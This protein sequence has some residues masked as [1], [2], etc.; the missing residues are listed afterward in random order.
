VFVYQNN[1]REKL[2]SASV[3]PVAL[4]ILSPISVSTSSKWPSVKLAA[5]FDE[6]VFLRFYSGQ[7]E[8]RIELMWAEGPNYKTAKQVLWRPS[9]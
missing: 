7:N 2:E 3:R 6:W 5:C 9:Q 1:T 8:E 4:E